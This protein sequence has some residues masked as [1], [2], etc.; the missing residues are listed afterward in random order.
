MHLVF[1]SK[2]LHRGEYLVQL[3]E[4][5]CRGGYLPVEVP[6]VDSHGQG[7]RLGRLTGIHSY[8]NVVVREHEIGTAEPEVLCCVHKLQETRNG[9]RELVEEGNF[10]LLEERGSDPRN[11]RFHVGAGT[12]EHKH[13]KVRK[14][15][16]GHDWCTLE[17]RLHITVGD[18]VQK[19]DH[20]RLQLWHE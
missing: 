7:I 13:T 15:G 8:V 20:E 11:N 14:R 2:M 17:L 16:M 6:A 19:K 12:S 4:N 10:E 5:L 1:K 9:K 3:I 18:R